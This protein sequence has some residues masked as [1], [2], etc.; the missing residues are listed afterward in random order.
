MNRTVAF[1][2]CNVV[3]PSHPFQRTFGSY[4]FCI[5]KCSIQHQHWFVL[6]HFSN[7]YT[8]RRMVGSDEL[9]ISSCLV[10][11]SPFTCRMCFAWKCVW[12]QFNSIIVIQVSNET[13][14]FDCVSLFLLCMCVLYFSSLLVECLC[15]AVSHKLLSSYAYE[16]FI[17]FHFVVA[18]SNTITNDARRTLIS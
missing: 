12:I 7:I 9:E 13:K 14:H 11:C 8:F 5:F 15:Y 18:H 6:Y 1:C 3:T 4:T 17:S 2:I 16:I 10:M